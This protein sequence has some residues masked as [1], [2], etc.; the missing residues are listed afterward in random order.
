[1][2]LE[3]NVYSSLPRGAVVYDKI[4]ESNVRT[5]YNSTA[6]PLPTELLFMTFKHSSLS[7]VSKRQKPRELIEQT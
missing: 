7:P 1:M 4:D 3:A 2:I 6:Y 5:I